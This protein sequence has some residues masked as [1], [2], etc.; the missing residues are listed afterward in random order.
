M[1]QASPLM[2]GRD[3]NTKRTKLTKNTKKGDGVR[4]D[5]G[6]TALTTNLGVLRG[7]RC[8]PKGAI[9]LWVE[10]PPGQW[11]VWPGSW[12]AVRLGN[13]PC[14]SPATKAALGGRANRRAVTC[15][16]P[17]QAWKGKLWTP[18]RPKYGEGGW[19]ACR[20]RRG[21]VT[22]RKPSKHRMRSGAFRASCAAEPRRRGDM[23]DARVNCPPYARDEASR[24]AGCG[25]SARPV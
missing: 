1:L 8:A 25:K 13:W 15:V 23:D 20:R 19:C 3:G 6:L 5:A 17:E 4:S 9:T 11:S 14:R 7:L 12:Q 10:V 2:A 22:W 18:T 16:K 21:S 24:K